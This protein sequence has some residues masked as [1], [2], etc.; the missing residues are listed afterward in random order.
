MRKLKVRGE[1]EDEEDF[2][3]EALRVKDLLLAEGATK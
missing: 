1:D 3:K 2:R